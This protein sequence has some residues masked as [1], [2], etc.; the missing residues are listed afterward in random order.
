MVLSSVALSSGC[1]FTSCVFAITA[2]WRPR[3]RRW[4]AQRALSRFHRGFIRWPGCSAIGTARLVGFENDAER[5]QP[6]SWSVLTPDPS[7][8]ARPRR[9]GRHGI[10]DYDARALCCSRRRSIRA[11]SSAESP[12]APGSSSPLGARTLLPVFITAALDAGISLRD[13]R[14]LP[15]MQTRGPPPPT[16]RG[17]RCPGPASRARPR[18]LLCL[19]HG[20][21]PARPRRLRRPRRLAVAACSG[22]WWR[23]AAPPIPERRTA[24]G[25]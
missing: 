6:G 25:S 7:G 16:R 13:T 21:D 9:A 23:A 15:R 14:K 8:G 22:P 19:R 18:C 5:S 12:A 11:G 20:A 3:S 4:C 17:S 10:A 1:H 24:P 2:V